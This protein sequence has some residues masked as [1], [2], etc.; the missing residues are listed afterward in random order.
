MTLTV[1]KTAL[2]SIMSE[3]SPARFKDSMAAFGE[4]RILS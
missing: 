1:A 3:I 4:E 2:A